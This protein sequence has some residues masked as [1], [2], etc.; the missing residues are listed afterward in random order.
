MPSQSG[1]SHHGPVIGSNS[2][3]SQK[4]M[5]DILKHQIL[6]KIQNSKHQHYIK[7]LTV[8]SKNLVSK[9]LVLKH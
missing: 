9:T 8:S 7:N 5:V 1:T 6:K 4:T 2:G 3:G